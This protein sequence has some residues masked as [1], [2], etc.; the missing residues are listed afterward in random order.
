VV[1]RES[2]KTAF[3]RL[4]SGLIVALAWCV[5]IW[6]VLYGLFEGYIAK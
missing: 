2:A 6:M 4:N 5:A 1:R 3:E